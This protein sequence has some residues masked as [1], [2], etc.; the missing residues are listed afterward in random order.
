MANGWAFFECGGAVFCI[1][2]IPLVGAIYISSS[3][4]S[5]P[6]DDNVE[7]DVDVAGSADLA[8]CGNAGLSIVGPNFGSADCDVWGRVGLSPCDARAVSPG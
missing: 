7:A 6:S 2:T 5:V 3:T 1:K 8:K 4:V